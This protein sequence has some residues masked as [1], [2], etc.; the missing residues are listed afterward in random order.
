MIKSF[1]PKPF[2]GLT[3]LPSYVANVQVHTL[4]AKA[5]GGYWITLGRLTVGESV[6]QGSTLTHALFESFDDHGERK[7]AARARANSWYIP[8]FVAVSE[9]MAKAGMEFEHTTPRTCED[10]IWE[11]KAWFERSN[12]E[13]TGF[14]YVSHL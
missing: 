14:R 11:L 8:V 10:I 6:S 2:E 13:L 12:P 3:P 7:A 9:A 5:P 1:S 4:E